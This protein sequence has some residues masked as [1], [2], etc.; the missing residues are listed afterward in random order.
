M[1]VASAGF[2]YGLPMVVLFLACAL[3]VLPP[4]GEQDRPTGLTVMMV[5]V[6]QG[7]G[8][9]VRTPGGAVT[10]VDA[11]PDGQGVAAM[12]PAIDSLQPTAYGH[13]F[14]S[15]FHDDHQGGMDEVL[16][17]PFVLAYDRGDV[18]RTNTSPATT[19]YLAAAGSRRRTIALGQTYGLG[20]DVTVRCVCVNGQVAGGGGLDPTGATQE[21]NARSIALRLDYGSFS[22]WIGGD[23]T[24]GGNSTPDVEGPASTSCGNVDV[25]KVNHHGSNTSTSLNLIS[26]LDPE[27]A[28]VSAGVANP[29]GHPT[30]TTVNR[31]VQAAAMRTLLCTTRGS[32]NLVGFAA[33]GN[34]RIDTDGWRY[35][36]TAQNGDF[37]DFYV[38]EMQPTPLTAGALRISEIQR[39]PGVVPDT[40]GEYFEVQALGPRPLALKGLRLRDDAA[41][42][43]LASNL[44]LLPGRPLVFAVDSNQQRNGGLPLGVGLPYQSIALGDATDSLAVLQGTSVIDQVVYGTGFPGGAGVAAER[45]DLQASATIANFAAAAATYGA[46]DRGSPGARNAADSTSH[47]VLVDVAATPGE[48]LLRGT[49]LALGSQWSAL[50]VAYGS[51]PGFPFL[52]VQIPLNYDPLLQLFLAHP[53]VVAPLPAGGFRSLAIAMPQPNPLRGVRVFAAHVV[54]DLGNLTVA[55]LSAALPLVI[56]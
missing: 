49:A 35:R 31:L 10:V 52:G 12:L 45:R 47:P 33:L 38:D 44:M 36:V 17:R 23:L 48:L 50:G 2:G 28:I 46:G 3:A 39:Q 14:L 34:I 37:L 20:D 56:P 22:M 53:G 11:G 8:L 40:N 26:R 19:D 55:G 16:Q 18:R 9:V 32:S 21:E 29:Y 4:Q 43:T 5:Q 1:L 13:A 6:G 41:T 24:G 27:L 30:T 54:L 7:D 25:Y 15:H 42:I 51:S